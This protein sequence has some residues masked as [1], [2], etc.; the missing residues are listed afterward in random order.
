MKRIL[1]LQGLELNNLFSI[2]HSKSCLRIREFMR[3]LIFVIPTI[4]FSGIEPG[5]ATSHR[6]YAS[7]GT[8]I[9]DEIAYCVGPENSM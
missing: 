9:P 2:A 1:L 7:N 5:K 4:K 3:K 6:S 8:D